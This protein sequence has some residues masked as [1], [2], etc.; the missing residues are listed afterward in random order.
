MK[1][2][3][4]NSLDSK[5]EKRA[6]KEHHNPVVKKKPSTRKKNE[7]VRLL[8][9]FLPE[10]L[11]DTKETIISDYVIPSIR[12]AAL[13]VVSYLLGGDGQIATTKNSYQRTSYQ[14][15]YNK[16]NANTRTENVKNSDLGYRDLIFDT[17]ADAANVLAAM[18]DALDMYG[19]VSVAEFYEF[20]DIST[21]NWAVNKYGW[22]D[23]SSASILHVRGGY[24]LKLPKAL[25]IE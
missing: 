3:P 11:N 20:A 1:H 15:H 22:T 6:K 8:E 24:I 17:R 25:P 4:S 2:Y 13:N 14:A 19:I 5:K 21:E 18:N 12:N 10:D 23:L 16:R 7:A 9:L